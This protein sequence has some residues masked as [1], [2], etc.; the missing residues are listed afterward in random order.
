[1]ESMEQM[2]TKY[3][4]I[5]LQGEYAIDTAAPGKWR[6]TPAYHMQRSPYGAAGAVMHDVWIQKGRR[7]AL[8]GF[9]GGKSG[10]GN[11]A[12]VY[13]GTPQETTVQGHFLGPLQEGDIIYMQSGGGGGWGLPWERDAQLVANDV[14]NEL[15]SAEAAKSDY[16]VVLKGSDTL[17]SV[18]TDELRAAHRSTS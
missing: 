4:L 5:Y 7:Y 14:R 8:Q 17:D 9:A 6:G 12:I 16:G 2:E 18:R 3:P 11:F 15:V 1:M 13:H 10:G